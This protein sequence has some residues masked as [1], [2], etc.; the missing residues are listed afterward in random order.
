[1]CVLSLYLLGPC[2]SQYEGNPG[3]I[4]SEVFSQNGLIIHKKV[5]YS[6]KKYTMYRHM[7]VLSFL[8]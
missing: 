2:K 1:M 8:F 3:L 7:L 6:S 4:S 5:E